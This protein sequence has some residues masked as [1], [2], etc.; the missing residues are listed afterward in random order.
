MERNVREAEEMA[1]S[2]IWE[3]E[4]P[5]S[6]PGAPIEVFPPERLESRRFSFSFDSRPHYCIGLL[7]RNGISTASTTGFGSTPPLIA[8]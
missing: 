6:N 1:D 8:G 3:Q 4:V 5:G 2:L 7:K